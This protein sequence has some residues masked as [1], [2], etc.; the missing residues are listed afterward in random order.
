MANLSLRRRNEPALPTRAGSFGLLDPFRMMDELLRWDPFRE[1]APTLRQQDIFMPAFEVS[2]TKD[3]F[4]FKADLPGVKESD[5][6][7]SISGNQLVVS[8]KRES[9]A[10]EEVQNYY[11][12]ERSFGSFTRSF[13]LPQ[14][15]DAD[16]VKADLSNGVL[17]LSVPKRPELQPRRIAVGQGQV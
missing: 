7:I 8:G 14:S 12:Y 15:A 16:N 11:A 10:Q 2:E 13:T 6:D 17:T 4:V 9:E 5:I 1:M 3:A